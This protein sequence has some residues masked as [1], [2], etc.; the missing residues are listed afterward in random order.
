M[1]FH[2]ESSLA[3]FEEL[4]NLVYEIIK[5]EWGAAFRA[6][7]ISL[8][9]IIREN[10]DVFRFSAAE[11][12]KDKR[13]GDQIVALL[14]GAYSLSSDTVIDRDAAYKWIVDRE[15]DWKN[16]GIDFESDQKRCLDTILQHKIRM[17]QAEYSIIS[18]IKDVY[19]WQ[20]DDPVADEG[21][22]KQRVLLMNG[23][24]VSYH[25]NSLYISN[26]HRAISDMLKQTPR[27]YRWHPVLKR[28]KTAIL[29][30]SI[31]FETG[32]VTRA[33]AINIDSMFD[34]TEFNSTEEE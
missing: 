24:K 15:S 3:K 8:L 6:R 4:Q 1:Q 26:T 33:I 17:G 22:E 23:I 11:Y 7:A 10:H 2:K 32:S 18:M 13:A 27:S 28:I 30:G 5:P 31:R 21:K 19:D 25:D 9:K 14:A 20:S 12:F 29:T 16:T 34:L